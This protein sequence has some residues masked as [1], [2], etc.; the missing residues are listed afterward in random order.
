MSNFFRQGK[1][2][3]SSFT[4]VFFMDSLY[5]LRYPLLLQS[6]R[7]PDGHYWTYWE[8]LMTPAQRCDTPH[9]G[10]NKIHAK[11]PLQW[12]QKKFNSGEE[13]TFYK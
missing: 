8:R 3:H 6:K 1:L 4:K 9:V 2:G 7:T 11:C 13:L 10:F 5:Y 12:P